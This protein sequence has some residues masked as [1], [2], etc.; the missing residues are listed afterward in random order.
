[1]LYLDPP[2]FVI[3]GVSVFADSDNP[4]DYNYLPMMPQFTMVAGP[5]GAS[6]PQ[7]QLIE[8]T[9]SAGTG[10]FLNFDVN[11]GISADILNTVAQQIQQQMNL[12]GQVRLS[13]V[14]FV[15][16]TVNL[17]VLGAQ[18][19]TPAAG[20]TGSTSASA[21]ASNTGAAVATAVA[22]TAGQPQ[23]VVK[24]QNATKPALYG[25]NQ[26]T[27][28]VQLD[29]YGASIL[30][31]A[32]SGAMAPVAV[33][34]SL[35]FL[36]LRPAFNV[37]ISADWNRVQ[38]YLD[39]EYSGGFL[40]F[41]S[42]IQ[43]TVEKLIESQI[44][45]IDVSTYTT[46]ADLG[47]SAGSD[48]DRAI[49][50]CY[51][52]VTTNFFQSS[53]PPPDPNKPDDLSK[54]MQAFQS[55]SDMAMTGGAAGAACFSYK[56]IDLTRTDAKSLNFD[57]SERTTVQ[58]TIYPQGHLS[59]LL[60][61]L[62]QRG[63]TL[64]QFIV[65]ADIGNPFFQRRQVTVTTH[66]DFQG[67][68]IASI[69]VNM[70]YNNIVKAVTLTAAAPQANADWN[71]LLV[72]GQMST[73]VAYSYTV[74]F[75]GVDTTQ[76]PGQLA[77]GILSALGN[78]DIEP[79]GQGPEN[80]Y[81]VTV[82][83]VRAFGLPWDRYPSVEVECQYADPANGINERP[84]AVLTSQ[85]PETDWSIFLRNPAL[86]T[87]LY[88]LTFTLAA[89]G[90]SK[91]DWISSS[92]A[93]INISD[94]FPAKIVLTV[95]AA[96][97]WS[98]FAEALLFLA[99]PSKENPIAQQTYTLTQ[100]APS[101]PAFEVDRQNA[102]QTFIYYEARLIQQNGQVWTVPG[103]VTS[104]AYLI[105][106]S[107]MKGHQIVTVQPEA[108]DFAQK[109]VTEVDVQLRYVDPANSINIAQSLAL[110]SKG[111]TRTFAYDYLNQQISAQYSA[112]IPLSNGQTK[113]IPWTAVSGNTVVIPLSQLD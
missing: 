26:A 21:G 42:Q 40:F 72:N 25:D 84:S 73:P 4:L 27:F 110:N 54:G 105:L 102:S 41:S 13:P 19:V 79:R 106:Q 11:L 68:S 113:S 83:P 64:D 34:Y 52:L 112:S 95:L 22:A 49:A 60:N 90:T 46:E 107:G 89:G 65:R 78:I 63:I 3:N 8:Y 74:N 99:Y 101:T 67:D 108:I 16:G 109:N 58:R 24:I 20:A 88:R 91:T 75:A 5:N 44:I 55:V 7:L 9:G 30:A 14:V 38:T 51:E 48:R 81:D 77:S 94:P 12:T 35:N 39:K 97:D 69:E 17:V 33:I 28:S 47:T 70:T 32:M 53:I 2:Y 23:F 82:I 111:D 87:F 85:N 92:S 71:S 59:G 61:T 100:N 45:T 50:E 31:Q 36:G 18:S 43:K 76:R 15:D 66:A 37:R 10:G 93:T 29:Q 98:V 56:S 86:R 62:T 104:D 80:L 6:L 57:V 1:M 103:S 96:L